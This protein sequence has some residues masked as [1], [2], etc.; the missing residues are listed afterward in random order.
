MKEKKT[1]VNPE[2][3]AVP[4]DSQIPVISPSA[5]TVV[6]GCLIE[7]STKT[8]LKGCCISHIPCDGRV[9]RIGDY[10][11]FGCTELNSITIPST[12]KSIGISAFQGTGLT[13]I[14]YIGTKDSWE[15]IVIGSNNSRLASATRYD[16]SEAMPYDTNGKYWHFVNGEVT[17]W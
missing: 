15:Q 1:Y 8:L 5:L 10:A 2:V 17:K 12:V 7:T 9:V 13:E 16:Y 6:E 14:Y 4:L 3:K 11:F